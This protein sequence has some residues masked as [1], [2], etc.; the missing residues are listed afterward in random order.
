MR[1][2]RSNRL[3]KDTVIRGFAVLDDEAATQPE[4]LKIFNE[5]VS[6]PSSYIISFLLHKTLIRDH[7]AGIAPT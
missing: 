2:C 3:I 7:N 4:N 6:T 1:S 5:G